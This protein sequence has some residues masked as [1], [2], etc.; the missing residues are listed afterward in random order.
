M[1]SRKITIDNNFA[2]D[3]IKKTFDLNGNILTI[4]GLNCES[5]KIESF[6]IDLN[7]TNSKKKE[8]DKVSDKHDLSLSLFFNGGEYIRQNGDKIK[9]AIRSYNPSSFYNILI[10]KVL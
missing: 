7:N 5:N 1:I 2:T 9:I 8:K 3:L 10:S 6:S 4:S